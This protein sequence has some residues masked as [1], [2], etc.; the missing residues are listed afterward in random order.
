MMV[1]I[2]LI[3]LS[4]Y[5]SQVATWVFFCFDE[6]EMNIRVAAVVDGT[7]RLSLYRTGD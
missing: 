4:I 3:G 6:E 7:E 5:E 2:F 1:F